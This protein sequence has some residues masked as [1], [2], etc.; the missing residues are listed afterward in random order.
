MSALGHKWTFRQFQAMSALPPESG[1]SSA[2]LE[3][4]LWAN[5]GQKADVCAM[6]AAPPKME[7]VSGYP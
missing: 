4:P 6:P 2:R 1:H 7:S 5:S 3:C